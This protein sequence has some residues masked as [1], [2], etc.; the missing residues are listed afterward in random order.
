[1]LVDGAVLMWELLLLQSSVTVLENLLMFCGRVVDDV[2]DRPVRN[3][4]RRFD[5]YSSKF[6]LSYETKVC[7]YSR[8]KA[9][10]QKV[11]PATLVTL[12]QGRR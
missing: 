6:S 1:M 8:K 7:Q 12:Q 5:E 10:L 2:N 4:K 9:K 11:M 3:P